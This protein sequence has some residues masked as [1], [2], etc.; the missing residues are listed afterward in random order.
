MFYKHHSSLI[1]SVQNKETNNIT[2][3]PA[4]TC[5]KDDDFA[6]I[7]HNFSRNT[8][9]CNLSGLSLMIDSYLS[10]INIHRVI[11]LE[12]YKNL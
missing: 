5:F 1:Y 7:L 10:V 2:F 6:K 8:L 9:F 11:R 12:Y 4:L 3:S